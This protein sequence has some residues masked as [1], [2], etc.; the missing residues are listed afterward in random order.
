ML[1]I[2]V[3][4]VIYNNTRTYASLQKRGRTNKEDR[5]NFQPTDCTALVL[6]GTIQGSGVGRSLITELER[7][8]FILTSYAKDALVGL[9]L[10]DAYLSRAGGSVTHVCFSLNRYFILIGF[11]QYFCYLLCFIIDI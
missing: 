7:N 10:S 4:P 9:I 3:I 2:Y 11:G 1:C 8:M 6:W 5:N